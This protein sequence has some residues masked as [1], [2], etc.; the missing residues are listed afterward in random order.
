MWDLIV[1]VPE[2]RGSFY[3]SYMTDT[4]Q[5]AGKS[6]QHKHHGGC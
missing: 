2:F 5:E 1:L 6:R 4:K 3:F